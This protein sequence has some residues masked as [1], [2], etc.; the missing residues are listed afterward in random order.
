MLTRE[1]SNLEGKVEILLWIFRTHRTTSED[2]PSGNLARALARAHK[3]DRPLNELAAIAG[4]FSLNLWQFLDAGG[5]ILDW[6]P[7][8]TSADVRKAV[9]KQLQAEFFN[10]ES[11]QEQ[12]DR[13]S[14]ETAEPPVS[15]CCESPGLMRRCVRCR[16][17][18]A[19][20]HTPTG[21]LGYFCARCCPICRKEK[22]LPGSGN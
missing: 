8:L 4:G 7:S 13:C 18:S 9:T 16:T 10:N 21:Q 6:R 15:R 14:G 11:Q 20:I 2:T 12:G 22:K 17:Q 3:A 19:V 5:K 1:I